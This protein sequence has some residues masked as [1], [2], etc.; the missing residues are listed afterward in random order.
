MPPPGAVPDQSELASHAV[1]QRCEAFVSAVCM[2][3]VAGRLPASAT[4]ITGMVA[5]RKRRSASRGTS[6]RLCV[7][8]GGGETWRPLSSPAVTHESPLGRFFRPGVTRDSN[9]MENESIAHPESA[10]GNFDALSVVV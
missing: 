1:R 6:T 4:E 2:A 5:G 8:R 7:W 10:A 9:R 3:L